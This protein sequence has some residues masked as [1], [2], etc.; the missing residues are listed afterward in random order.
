MKKVFIGIDFS[1]L[2]FDAVLLTSEK[3]LARIHRSF[4]NQVSGYNDFIQWIKSNTS[5]K[6][7]HW[8]VC[9]EH[10]GLYSLNLTEY[11]NLKNIDIWL[12]SPLQIKRSMGVQRSKTDKIDA[13][14][15]ALYAYRFQDKAVSTKIKDQTLDQ[16]KDLQAYRR[17]LIGYRTSLNV[18]VKELS[19]VKDNPSVDMIMAGSLLQIETIN[20]QLKLVNQ[21]IHSLITQDKGLFEN[22][23]LLTSIKG[24]GQENAI[25]M[26]ILTGNFTLFN[27]PRKFGCYC[28]VVPFAHSS[29]TSL[30]GTD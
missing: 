21:K 6:K 30:K 4:E 26:L 8:L 24:I 14:Q 2:K 1:K 15:I 7:G 5:V 18:A 9:G 28:G 16:I 13:L 20:E 11:L 10:T 23:Q 25:M 3:N 12:E 19:R 27:E 22:Y 29:G 17:R